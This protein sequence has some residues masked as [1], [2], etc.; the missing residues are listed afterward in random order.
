MTYLETQIIAFA[1]VS[2]QFDDGLHTFHLT[3]NG[4]VEVLLLDVWEE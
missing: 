1:D 3:L 2:G 4:G